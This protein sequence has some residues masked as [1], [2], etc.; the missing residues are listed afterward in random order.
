M[1]RKKINYK[2]VIRDV[3]VGNMLTSM[4]RAFEEQRKNESIL[5]L[6]QL[7][8]DMSQDTRGDDEDCQD[9]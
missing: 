7:I 5:R 9:F 4:V 6:A 3:R 8:V 1:K 2:K